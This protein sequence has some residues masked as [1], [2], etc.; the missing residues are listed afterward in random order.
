[1][2]NFVLNQ[3]TTIYFGNDSVANIGKEAS[4]YSKKALIVYGSDRIE[5]NGVLDQAKKYLKESQVEVSTLSGVDPNPRITSVRKGIEICRKQNIGVLLPI[6]GGSVIDCAKAI[7]AGFYCDGD[8]W[9]LFAG[10]ATIEKA[11]PLGCVLTLAATGTEMNGNTV[12]S[13][14]ETKQKIGAGSP[15]LRP[16]FSILDPEYTITVPAYHTAAGTFDIISHVFEQY[17]DA[18]K[19]YLLDRLSEAVVKT[20]VEFGPIAMKDPA[21][22]EARTNLMWAGTLALNG[23]LNTG[24]GGDWAVH[25]IEHELSA[26]YDITH[27]VGL[28]IL[29]PAWMEYVLDG[30]NAYKFTNLGR[31]VFGLELNDDSVESAKKTID[32]LRDFIQSIGMPLSLKEVGIGQGNLE[33][34]ASNVTGGG[35]STVGNFKSLEAKDVLAIYKKCLN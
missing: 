21:N 4:E 10:T 18:A 34:M 13:N 12:I 25:P 32:A 35:K 24:R 29:T 5:K 33:I 27:G 16:K 15:L 17:F 8:A 30:D 6:G 9:D 2:N 26:Y 7:A 28:A 19:T 31:G 23:L 3:P 20:C 1:M 22:I 11:L 14:L